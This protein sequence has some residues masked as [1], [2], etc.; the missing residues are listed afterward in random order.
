MALV[1]QH[2]GRVLGPFVWLFSALMPFTA[3]GA[4]APLTLDRAVA[5]GL[6]H[7]PAIEARGDTIEAM[8]A[9]AD[10]AGRLPDPS[11][12]VGMANYPVTPPDAIAAGAEPM[13]MRTI[14]V[15][16]SIPSRAM[17]RAERGLADANIAV[18]SAARSVSVEETQQ[19][20][21]GAWIAVWA[22]AQRHEQLAQLR[23]E[24]E[25]AVRIARARLSGGGGGATDVLAAR[26]T[27]LALENRIDAVDAAWRAARANLERWIGSST[28]I[29]ARGADFAHLPLAPQRI[30]SAVDRQAPMQVW[31]ARERAAAAALTEARASRRPDF[32]VGVSYGNR[33]PGRSDMVSLQFGMSLPLFTRHR[34]DAGIS[35]EHATWRAVQADREDARRAQRASVAA[36]LAI[37][38]GWTRQ[39]DRDQDDLLPL[40]RDRAR[41]ALAAYR[42]GGALEPWIDARRDEIELRLR[43]VDALADR[44]RQWAALAY[45]VPRQGDLP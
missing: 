29:L 32:S 21:A 41:A 25:L 44:A 43:Y 42:G 27:A 14:G 5:L 15:T 12:S 2:A 8:H 20:I 36:T 30:E 9:A 37:W 26:M 4:D 10:R 19:R 33:G 38:R 23:D 35:A 24:S 34:Q 7:A 39:I 3:Y 1:S 22:Q 13:T 31:A 17:R 45:L 18:A 28:P 6:A 40:A 16:Q 11:L